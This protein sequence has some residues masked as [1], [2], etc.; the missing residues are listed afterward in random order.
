MKTFHCGRIYSMIQSLIRFAL[1]NIKS[2]MRP[3]LLLFMALLLPHQA[4]ALDVTSLR[5][6]THADSQRV[7]IELSDAAKF[8]TYTMEGPNR[9]IVDL[10]NFKWKVGTIQKPVTSAITDI[11]HGPIGS[12]AARI[13][14]ETSGKALIASSFLLPSNDKQPNRI[15]IDFGSTAATARAIADKDARPHSASTVQ[16]LAAQLPI[17]VHQKMNGAKPALKITK[18]KDMDVSAIAAQSQELPEASNSDID[19]PPV[20]KRNGQKPLIIIDPG[21]GGQDP[22]AHAANGNYEKSI[23]LAVGLELKKTLEDSGQYRVQMT[24]D[25][26]IFIPLKDRVK[27]A[28]R[29]GGDL[30]V[31][32]H[33]DSMPDSTVTGASVYTLSDTASDKEAEKLA[34]RENKSDAIAGVNLANQDSD[35]ANILIDLASRD[36]MNQSR[37]LANTVVSTMP[38]TGVNMLSRQ[39]HRSAG[40]AVL[41]AMDIPSILVEMGYL[42]NLGESNRLSSREYRAKIAQGLKKSI[43]AYFVKVAKLT[44]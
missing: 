3:T 4:L 31:S 27:F 2:L 17:P 11:R 7:V 34:E 12:D 16:N 37:Y 30:F 21:H 6:G 44:P 14:L 39:P 19:T 5:F 15:V 26:D 32:L 29:N 1:S 25:R 13:V 36:T 43:D 42:T 20:T 22:G 18:T 28:R 33:A 38:S 41:K 23:V 35:V 40:F 8:K 10:P 24:R 9:I